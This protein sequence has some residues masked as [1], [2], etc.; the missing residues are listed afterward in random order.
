MLNNIP[1]GAD[2]DIRNPVLEEEEIEEIE[3]LSYEQWREERDE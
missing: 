1:E 3:D 2:L